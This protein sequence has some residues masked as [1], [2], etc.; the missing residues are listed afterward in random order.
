MYHHCSSPFR[1]LWR[2]PLLIG[3]IVVS[4]LFALAFGWLVMILWNWLMP[5]MFSLPHITYWQGFGIL[6]LSKLLLGVFHGHHNWAHHA[7]MHKQHHRRIWGKKFGNTIDDEW[8]PDGD[9]R[10]WMFYRTYWKEK[11]KKDFEDYLKN[12]GN[13]QDTTYD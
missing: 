5:Y 10:N 2:I 11:G 6:V 3:G 9:Y 4:G 12:R 13:A 7:N 8:L 1:F